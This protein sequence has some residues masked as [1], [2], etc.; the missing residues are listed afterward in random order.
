MAV[1]SWTPEAL[2]AEIEA[3]T[4]AILDDVAQQIA[5]SA[6]PPVDTGFLQASAYTEPS[7]YGD[8]WPT[9]QYPDRNGRMV[10]RMQGDRATPSA[11]PGAVVGWSAEHAWAIEETQ[12]FIY[13]AVSSAG[14]GG[15]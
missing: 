5:D 11:T 3:N 10:A 7:G 8:P 2:N 4:Q 1:T 14:G 13:I 12:P 15:E 6:Q 9:G